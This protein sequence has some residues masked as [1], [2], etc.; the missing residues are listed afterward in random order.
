MI[1]PGECECKYQPTRQHQDDTDEESDGVMFCSQCIGLSENLTRIV[2]CWEEQHGLI[3]PTR[4]YEAL[5]GSAEQ[6]NKKI[7]K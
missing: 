7:S 1:S 4:Q 3:V 6:A 5:I 2:D